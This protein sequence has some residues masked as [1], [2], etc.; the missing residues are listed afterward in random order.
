MCRGR[1][2]GPPEGVSERAAATEVLYG[3]LSYEKENEECLV[4]M[5]R[6]P[7]AR[8][9]EWD[10]EPDVEEAQAED[11]W[12]GLSPQAP[13]AAASAPAAGKLLPTNAACPAISS[14]ARNAARY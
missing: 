3:R 6:A 7:E 11:A 2:T 13:E 10:V 5:E 8:G 12:A 4:E 9:L 14:A 1:S